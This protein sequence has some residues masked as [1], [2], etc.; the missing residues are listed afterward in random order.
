MAQHTRAPHRRSLAFESLE[1]RQLMAATPVAT[2]VESNDGPDDGAVV[3]TSNH[4]AGQ[5]QMEYLDRGVIAV[6]R[7]TMQAY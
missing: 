6:R 1:S 5:R 2:A 3:A 4:H 7:S